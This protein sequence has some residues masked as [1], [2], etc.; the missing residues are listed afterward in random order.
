[1]VGGVS[2]ASAAVALSKLAH[3]AP[4][5]AYVTHFGKT[6]SSPTERATRE[7]IYASNLAKIAAQNALTNSWIAGVNEF[8]DWSNT[9][10]RAQRTSSLPSHVRARHNSNP[11]PPPSLSAVAPPP[12][13]VDWR[14][15]NVLSPVKNQGGCGSCW[16]FSAVETFEAALAMETGGMPKLLSTQQ[17]VA[18]SPNPN[19]CGGT[20]GCDGSTQQLAF[21][22]TMLA[23][24]TTEADYPYEGKTGTC[25]AGAA[26]KA[27]AKNDGF[28]TVM[29]NNYTDLVATVAKRPVAITVAAG[30]LGWQ[31]YES[32]VY[33]GGLFGCGFELDHGVQLVGYGA[34]GAKLYWIVRNSWGG[35]WGQD[36]YMYLERYGEGKEPC[37]ID[38]K[39]GDGIACKG[40]STQE[41]WC[42]ECGILSSSSYPQGVKPV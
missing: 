34:D 33:S 29:P 15:K 16:A 27:V 5:A 20:G 37:G 32:G 42:G 1:M 36:G 2:V 25:N 12:D 19:D 4:F 6:Y 24:I 28:W 7:A 35:G 39:P 26:A 38:K 31:L 8:T 41:T 13:T 11:A 23:G 9:E 14:T 10:F 21:N 22:Y 18:C 30:G 40:D 3:D 17:I